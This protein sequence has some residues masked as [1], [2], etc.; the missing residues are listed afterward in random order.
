MNFARFQ[1]KPRCPGS[2]FFLFLNWLLVGEQ[3]A[4]K[5]IQC[6]SNVTLPTR[7]EHTYEMYP[8]KRGFTKVYHSNKSKLFVVILYIINC[9]LFCDIF[10]VILGNESQVMRLLNRISEIVSIVVMGNSYLKVPPYLT[11]VLVDICW[12]LS[13]TYLPLFLRLMTRV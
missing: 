1:N 8:G 3:L 9:I 6:N 7:I 4:I 11:H 13:K 5:G 12:I 10:Q 2:L